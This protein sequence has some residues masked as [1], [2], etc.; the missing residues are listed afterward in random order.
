MDLA[1]MPIDKSVGIGASEAAAA[2]GCSRHTTRMQLF[3]KKKG[4]MQDDQSE[5]FEHGLG[6]E[7]YILDKF[8][9]KTDLGIK[10]KQRTFVH[11]Q[12]TYIYATPD[13]LTNSHAPIDAKNVG[14]Y[15]RGLW[16]LPGDAVIVDCEK[17]TDLPPDY[18]WQAQHQALVLD[19]DH[20]FMVPFFGG[21]E[22]RIMRI[23]R[24]EAHIKEVLLPAL[25]GF[26]I[27]L[28]KDA[29]PEPET[30]SDIKLLY[31][32]SVEEVIEAG[33]DVMALIQEHAE[34]KAAVKDSPEGKRVK[35][36]ELEI[37]KFVGEKE[38]VVDSG[39]AVVLTFKSESRGLRFDTKR[40]KEAHPELHKEFSEAQTAR[41][42]RN[43]L[44]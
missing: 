31:P 18:Y 11:P 23:P 34:L 24:N 21:N 15:N 19:A 38:A 40:F 25:Q 17:H 10:W 28:D 43:K 4:R 20:A 35:E 37:K 27:C 7:D 41:V 16:N 6:L 9:E 14:L 12:I 33:T 36:L 1:I 39:G 2:I 13:A 22:H 3:L 26:H 30:E 32:M 29:M 44:K 5:L 42:L 8:D